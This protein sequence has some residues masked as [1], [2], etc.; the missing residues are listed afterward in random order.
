MYG[1]IITRSGKS[2][3]VWEKGYGT[4]TVVIGNQID[5]Y[6][7]REEMESHLGR[8]GLMADRPYVPLTYIG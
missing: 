3:G 6:R 4:Y 5:V 8:R 2:V 7:T 1:Q